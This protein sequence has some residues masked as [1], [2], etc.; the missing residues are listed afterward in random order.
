MLNNHLMIELIEFFITNEDKKIISDITNHDFNQLLFNLSPYDWEKFK[1]NKKH[2]E[3]PYDVDGMHLLRCILA[4]KILEHRRNL[5]GI[6]DNKHYYEFLENG[7]VV[8]NDTKDLNK[9]LIHLTTV[10]RDYLEIPHSTRVDKKIQSHE[11]DLQRTLH[12]DTFHS[13]FKVFAYLNDVKVENGPFCYV[14]GSHKNTKQKL[15]WLYDASVKRSDLILNHGL[16]REE[17]AE[18]WN[19]SFRLFCG[20]EYCTDSKTI[21]KYLGDNDLPNETLVTGNEGSIVVA[22]TSGLHRRYNVEKERHTSRLV[23]DRLN[24]FIV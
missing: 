23:L 9:L 18:I 17:N 12:V 6:F 3:T 4:E 16:T 22:D 13:S 1:N 20:K 8:L 2:I 7:F 10:V 14:K 19:D 21:N 15:K 24:P 11:K 5:I